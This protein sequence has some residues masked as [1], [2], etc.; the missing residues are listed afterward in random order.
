[1]TLTAATQKLIATVKIS[2]VT[3]A[4]TNSSVFHPRNPYPVTSMN[5]RSTRYWRTKSTNEVP[6]AARGRISFGKYTF[7]T[8]LV[9]SMIERVASVSDPEK[10]FQAM[11]PE[12]R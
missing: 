3:V 12:S 4:G 7:F 1:V 6:T 11:T 9:L 5:T 2:M 10:K 8:R